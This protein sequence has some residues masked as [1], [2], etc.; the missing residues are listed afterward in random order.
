MAMRYVEK[1]AVKAALDKD[2]PDQL[3]RHKPP[4]GQLLKLLKIGAILLLRCVQRHCR[5]AVTEVDSKSSALQGFIIALNLLQDISKVF[6]FSA[7]DVG[8]FVWHDFLE[9]ALTPP[10]GRLLYQ[11]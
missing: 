5:R 4:V 6:Q 2:V 10:I 9:A 3:G 7:K 1:L 11:A 8:A